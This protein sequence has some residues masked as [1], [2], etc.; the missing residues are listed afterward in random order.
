MDSSEN[1]ALPYI[2]AGQSQKHVTHN[3]ALRALDA[4]VQLAVADKDLSTPPSSPA[5]GV[6]Y[7][8][9]AGPSG[10]WSGHANHVAAWQDGAWAFYV[11][12]AGWLAWVHDESRLYLYGG[13]G[14]T[15][16]PGSG[17]A[18]LVPR[19]A[20]DET[21]TYN[22]GDLVERG[23]Y[24]FLS[25]ADDNI[26]NE[27]DAATPGSTSNWTYFSVISSGGGGGGDV[28]PVPLVGINDTADSTNRLAVSSPATLLSHEGDDHQLKINKAAAADT[29]SVLFQTDFV[30][31]AEFG[32][33]GDN[34]WH[35]KVSPDGTTWH[36]ALV[37]N[38]NTGAVTLPNTPGGGGGSGRELLTADRT[39]YVDTDLGDDGND[40][41][42][43]GAGAFATIQAAV[44]AAALLDV[45]IYD[46]TISV[47]LHETYTQQTQIKSTVGAG[48]VTIEADAA[49]ATNLL[50]HTGSSSTDG[51]I[52]TGELDIKGTWRLRGFEFRTTTNGRCV[53]VQGAGHTL[54]LDGCEFGACAREHVRA[55][56]GAV[57]T[58]EGDY[59]IS[60]SARQHWECSNHA[61]IDCTALT[62]TLTGTPNF[63]T[64][65]V[66]TANMGV[67]VANTLTFSGSATGQRFITLPGV[68]VIYTAGAGTSYFPGNSGGS[69]A[70]P[71]SYV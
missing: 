9:G 28:N 46:V 2:M 16:A 30:G 14:W 61:T 57:V 1:L 69:E 45:G 37:V 5:P 7:I 15:E 56:N 35:V 54:L 66:R 65:F 12:A 31:H 55:Y 34:D 32:L 48:V 71:D 18:G 23:G 33:A 21:E 19:G 59:T 26:D 25:N 62:I 13:G 42:S 44:D 24:A 20:W 53:Q 11:P 60:G 29:A 3:E 64:A 17:G 4:I 40:G 68:S 49:G 52:H 6:R 51:C 8:V 43:S 58:F 47:R 70:S 39:Y 50:H 36:E 41:L 38:R 22:I 10:A 67:I 27:P 63:S